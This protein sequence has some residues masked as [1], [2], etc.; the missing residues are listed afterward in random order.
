MSSSGF[1]WWHISVKAKVSFLATEAGGRKQPVFDKYRYSPNHKLKDGL[2]CM[3]SFTR[4]DGGK[5]EPG[6]TALVDITFVVIEPLR[7]FFKEGLVWDIHEGSLKIGT[8]EILSIIEK[9]EALTRE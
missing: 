3:G 4:I 2:F 7:G 6:E 5:I 8:G 1:T 9:K